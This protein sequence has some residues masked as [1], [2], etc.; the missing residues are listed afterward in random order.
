M[1]YLFILPAAFFFAAPMTESL[2]LRAD[3]RVR[4]SRAQKRYFWGCVFGALAG[5]TRSVGGL[6]LVFVAFSGCRTCLPTGARARSKKRENACPRALCML[7]VPFGLAGYL[8]INYA[9][10]GN[11]L[12]FMRYQ[13][14][15]WGRASAFSSRARPRSSS[16]S[17]FPSTGGR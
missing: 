4:L 17:Y 6:I 13:S 9:V 11:A 5:F 1:K 12:T 16:T 3:A 15:H 7:V 8:Y 14:E 10:T 2:F